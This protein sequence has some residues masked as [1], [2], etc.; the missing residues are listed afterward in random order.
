MNNRIDDPWYLRFI[1]QVGVPAAIACGLT[2]FLTWVVS[3]DMQDLRRSQ[4][5]ILE[6]VQQQQGIDVTIVENQKA[7]IRL[8]NDHAHATERNGQ[9]LF[10][11]CI[12]LAKGDEE[13]RRCFNFAEREK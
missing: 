2:F 8:V 3:R 10:A 11:I 13:R 5:Q 7:I 6:M 1:I 9:T 4:Q 12:N